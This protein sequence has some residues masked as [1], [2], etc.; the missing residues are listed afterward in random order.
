MSETI[1][2]LREHDHRI[3]Q[4][5]LDERRQLWSLFTTLGKQ[6][7][8]MPG[9][10]L[11]SRLR[12]FCQVLVDYISLGHFEMYPRLTE[13]PE[14][15]NQVQALAKSLYPRFMEAT[16]AAVEF[17]DK[18]EKLEDKALQIEL[19]SDLSRLGEALAARF[20]LEDQLIGAMGD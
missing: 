17:N 8:F 3:V 16:D 7:P 5:L 12:E 9:Q 13:I 4:E 11:E 10:V 19:E 14:R 20:D 6:K 18:Y 15:R 2:E 1:L